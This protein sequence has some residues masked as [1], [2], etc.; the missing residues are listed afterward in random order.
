[1]KTMKMN[2]A[3][4][5]IKEVGARTALLVALFA[6]TAL[7][8]CVAQSGPTK[9]KSF[10]SPLLA[11]H[12]L[13]E[14]VQQDDK[15]TIMAILGARKSLVSTDKEDRYKDERA[16]FVQKYQEMH[17]LVREPDGTTVLIIGAENWQFPFPLI[18]TKGSWH[19]DSDAGMREVVFRRIGENESAAIAMC[20]SL[21]RPDGPGDNL[22]AGITK[23]SHGYII[24]RVV[25]RKSKG[26]RSAGT[27]GSSMGKM[28]F[29]A[30][31]EEYRSS[32]VMTFMVNTEGVVYARDLGPDSIIDP[33]KP[34]AIRPDSSWTIEK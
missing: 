31:P 11:A 13:F 9:Q 22:P 32:G 8:T 23:T 26:W 12:A 27:G 6:A 28:L 1:M 33:K 21:V 30:Y 34:T 19:F 3:A 29:V 2:K 14:A 24:L 7:G 15:A 4:M 5:L 10:D 25:G 20:K 17:R 16:R 18:G